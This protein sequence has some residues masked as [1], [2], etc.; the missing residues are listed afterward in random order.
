MFYNILSILGGIAFVIAGILSFLQLKDYF[1]PLRLMVTYEHCQPSD[2]ST[3]LILYRLSFVNPASR[4]RTVSYLDVTSIVK[5][6]PLIELKT[7]VEPNLQTVT[8]SLSN[9]SRRLPFAEILQL[10]L[11]IPPNQSLSKWKAIAVSYHK[12]GPRVGTII[13]FEVHVPK[14]K[15]RLEW[16]NAILRGKMMPPHKKVVTSER[17]ILHP[18]IAQSRERFSDYESF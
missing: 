6:I 1:R 12:V 7:E 9:V 5:G 11:D 10:P 18:A 15:T 13:R 2:N 8:Y 3:S 4:G 14:G 17:C 16:D